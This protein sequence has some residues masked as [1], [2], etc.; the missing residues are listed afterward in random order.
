[1]RWGVGPVRVPDGAAVSG[2][3]EKP[4]IT[5]AGASL[6]GQEPEEIG[7]ALYRDMKMAF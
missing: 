1:M 6:L 3:W 2:I 5:L 4:Q 7:I